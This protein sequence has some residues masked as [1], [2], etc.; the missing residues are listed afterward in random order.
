MGNQFRRRVMTDRG[1]S[2]CRSVLH[3]SCARML[4][5]MNLA[6]QAPILAA[7]NAQNVF[8]DRPEEAP[9]VASMVTDSADKSADR[10]D[11]IGS[12][13]NQIEQS[14]ASFTKSSMPD[15]EKL[16]VFD[17]SLA[18]LDM[19]LE[20]TKKGGPLDSLCTKAIAPNADALK[21]LEAQQGSE[22][23]TKSRSTL[24]GT[25]ASLQSKKDLIATV[26]DELLAKKKSVLKAQ[27]AFLLAERTGNTEA[28]KTALDATMATVSDLN[29]VIDRLGKVLSAESHEQ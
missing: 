13:K 19:L 29:A 26:H 5:A 7:G 3:W 28:A 4:I 2:K 24:A 10:S 16:K 27:L 15:T 14:M 21:Q 1:F 20:Q 17:K 8:E 25:I 22:S 12:L 11:E 23:P 9:R 6:L 18:D